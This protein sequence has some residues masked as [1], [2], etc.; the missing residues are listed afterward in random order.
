MVDILKEDEKLLLSY[1]PELVDNSQWVDKKLQEN[2]QVTFRRTFTFTHSDLLKR[3]KQSEFFDDDFDYQ[4][5]E[6]IFQ[7]GTLKD[8]YYTIS[9]DILG[10]KHDLKLSNKIKIEIRTFT[11]YRDISI[12][13]KIDDLIDEPIIVGD[14]DNDTIPLDDFE[15]LLKNFP[16][17]TELTHY[18]GTPICRILREYFDTMSD[19]EAKLNQH[20]K[21]KKKLP[22]TSRES[23]VHN[24]ELQKFEY[25]HDE[26]EEMLKHTDSYN[27]SNWQAKVL[28][29]LLFIFPK[30]IA[31]LENVH[32]K[33]FYT[34]P[35][36]ISNCYIDLILVDADGNI[37]IIEVKKPFSNSL[38]SRKPSYRRNHTPLK[39]LSGA[40]MQAEK[41]IFHL[42]KWGYEGEQEIY[43]K[44][45][46]ELPPELKLKITNPK[47]MI[48]MGRDNNFEGQQAFDFEIIRRK[49]ANVLDIMTYDD[50]LRRIKNII[51]MMKTKVK[52]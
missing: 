46:T 8:G 26:L 22:T 30:Y 21:R 38:L 41:Y 52:V 12:F 19:A 2:D 32:V 44:R 49:Y 18:S 13:R 42:S 1:K 15:L 27:E 24:F 45:K 31:I 14:G 23:I 4:D 17:S 36:K 40:I 10:L 11:A 25:V 9:K 48:L 39:E 20:L 16:T 34:E 43:K 7:L 6:R 51:E 3:T 47:A 5:Q 33:D 37:D 35:N 50:L 29:L 28:D